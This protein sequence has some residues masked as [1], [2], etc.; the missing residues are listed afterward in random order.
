MQKKKGSN[1]MK[2]EV[3]VTPREPEPEPKTFKEW[4]KSG[5]HYSIS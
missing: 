3:A 2:D 1:R 5:K 4:F